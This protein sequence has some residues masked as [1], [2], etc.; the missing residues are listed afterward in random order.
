MTVIINAA[1]R[2]S[3]LAGYAPYGCKALL[4][5]GGTPMIEWQ[6]DVVGSAT[7]VCRPEHADLLRRYGPVAVDANDLGPASCLTAVP[8]SVT[9]GP[10][11]VVYA[12][13]WFSS[14]PAGSDWV[15]VAEVA[16]RARSWDVVDDDGWVSYR[17]PKGPARVCVGVYSFSNGDLIRALVASS[18][19]RPVGMADVLAPYQAT[20][21]V[22]FVE[23]ADWQDVGDPAAWASW[24][25]PEVA[26]A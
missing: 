8:E 26:D 14:L 13:S 22:E 4:E 2:A 16:D 23:M 12:D 21:P 18:G 25:R 10:V 15:G 20:H 5:V 3:R 6:L 9:A 7:I 19:A 17:D 1:G 24:K 11:T